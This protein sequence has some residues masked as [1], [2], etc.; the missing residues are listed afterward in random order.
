MSKSAWA[1]GLV[2]FASMTLVGCNGG[3]GRTHTQNWYN[4]YGQYC[5]SGQPQPGCNFYWDGTKIIDVEDPY[6]AGYY[7]LEFGAWSYYD[8]YGYLQIY[9]GWGWVSPTGILY[10]DWGNALNE[11]DGEKGKDVIADVAKKEQQV[12]ETVGKKFAEEHALSNAAGINIA[13][14]LHDWATLPKQKRARTD[15]DVADFTRRL[16]GVSVAEVT[17]ALEKAKEGELKDAE[18]LNEKVATHWGTSPETSKEVLK[19]WYGK[20]LDEY[21]VD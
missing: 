15:K 11:E 9:V 18:A 1:L 14:T 13:K 16:Y 19:G 12:V 21:K 20:Y 2:L 6:F 7:N 10:D 8:S 5:G 17:A 3:G 4:V